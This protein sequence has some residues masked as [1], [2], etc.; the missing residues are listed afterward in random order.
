MHKFRISVNI[1]L[2]T[3]RTIQFTLL[4]HLTIL[5]A[6]SSSSV[7]LRR[8]SRLSKPKRDPDFQYMQS[9][10]DQLDREMSAAGVSPT[11]R[12]QEQTST[13]NPVPPRPLLDNGPSASFLSIAEK[14][15]TCRV[16]SWHRSWRSL[17]SEQL[18]L[19]ALFPKTPST[20]PSLLK[21]D[22]KE[23]NHRL[24]T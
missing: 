23:G 20:G 1:L 15:Q 17:N 8:S 18:H 14:N 3:I 12:P 19:I 21:T 2:R 7:S 22:Q 24:A 13:I 5:M 9:R 4:T 10:I 11:P 16:T 6:Q